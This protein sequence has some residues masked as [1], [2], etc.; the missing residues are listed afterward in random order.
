MNRNTPI[1][2]PETVYEYDMQNTKHFNMPL[3]NEKWTFY[4]ISSING[5]MFK[6]HT[7]N[8]HRH[9]MHETFVSS[10]GKIHRNFHSL[11]EEDFF[12]ILV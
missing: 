3:L 7:Y 5:N 1:S 9:S 12:W 2:Y 8:I 11:N 6:M 4:K 10:K